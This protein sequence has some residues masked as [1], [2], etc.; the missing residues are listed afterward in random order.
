[1]ICAN[2]L[3]NYIVFDQFADILETFLKPRTPPKNPLKLFHLVYCKLYFLLGRKS[4]PP[5]PRKRSEASNS[6]RASIKF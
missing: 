1:M 4:L 3:R 5:I 6:F 2:G